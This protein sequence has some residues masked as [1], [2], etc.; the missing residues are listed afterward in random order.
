MDFLA[1]H[2]HTHIHTYTH[3]CIHTHINTCYHPT[4]VYM[5]THTHKH[6]LPSYTYTYFYILL[7]S[8]YK[9]N[10]LTVPYSL[11]VKS[12]L[13]LFKSGIYSIICTE[14][15]L[16]SHMSLNK[17]LSYCRFCYYKQCCHVHILLISCSMHITYIQENFPE[18]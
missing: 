13:T 6:M 3:M 17:H 8:L 16:F 11:T 15:N 5:H 12:C 10:S 14:Y 4:H 1:N 7:C 9:V 18:A 2:S